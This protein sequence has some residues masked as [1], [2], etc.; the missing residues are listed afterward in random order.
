MGL[1]NLLMFHTTGYGQEKKVNRDSLYV[2]KQVDIFDLIR[3]WTGKPAKVPI[4][5]PQIRVKNLSLLPIVGYSPANGFVVGGAVSVTELLGNPKTTQLSSAL[6]NASFTTKKQI[7]LNLR[8]DLFL[9][10]NKWF[11]SGD[12]RLLFF[13]QPTYGLGIYGLQGQSY[14]FGIN[15]SSVT[16]TDSEQPMRFN[17]IRLY[18][19]VS[20]RI[21]GKWYAGM[22]IMIDY[23][24][25]IKD[26]S[27]KVDTPN[28]HLTSHYI[29]SKAYG[30]DTSHYSANGLSFQ[31][32]HDSR[33]NPVNAFSG[34]YLN[35]AFRV[36]EVAF[37]STQNSTMLYYEWRNYI[38]VSKRIPRN[39]LAFWFW[40]VLVTSGQ[41][42]YLALPSITWDTY[43]RSGRGYIQGRFR[44]NNM[45][46]EEA[47][48]RYRITTDG[49]L[50]GVVFT[51]FTTASNPL[52][53]EK[54]FNSVAPGYG[55]GLRIKMNKKDR[56]N[57]AIDYG[58]GDGFTGIYFNIREAF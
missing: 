26:Q 40:G 21:I 15:G 33:D 19:T 18:E 6:L 34:N 51:N 35:L 31:I 17:Y 22:G 39:V 9:K 20:R 44:G 7:L 8:F 4:D 24:F 56:T 25:N 14:T 43:N 48:F 55:F 36:N 12:N 23:D 27:L 1:F 28:Q 45:I 52:T 10:E 53:G 54:A 37:G 38:S 5:T 16:R 13:A 3:K 50:G 42:P 47:E 58:I 29:Y 30:F 11:I 49:L 2:A 41:V 46:Y 57:I 32:L